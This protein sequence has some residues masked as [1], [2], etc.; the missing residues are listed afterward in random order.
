MASGVKG[1]AAKDDR[2]GWIRLEEG[3]KPGACEEVEE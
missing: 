3:E 1:K 2:R